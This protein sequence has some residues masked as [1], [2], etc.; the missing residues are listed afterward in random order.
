M[1]TGI[2]VA[3]VANRALNWLRGVAP[4]SVPGL[5]VQLHLGDPGAAGT[6]NPSAV[7]ARVQA[8]ENAASGGS[9]T[10]A[11]VSGPWAMT[12][13]E[14][15][16]HISVHDAASGG[17]FLFSA[18][19]VTPRNVVNGDTVTLTTLTVANTPLAA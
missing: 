17:N 14:T 3:N 6:A 11:S 18:A 2:S 13:T 4:P 8:T 12:A 5:Y 1:A 9:M 10:L 15:I 19:L 7:T 16:S